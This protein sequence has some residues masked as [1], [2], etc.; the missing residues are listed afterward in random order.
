MSASA[1]GTIAVG[2]FDTY[3][4]M[5]DGE[6]PIDHKDAWAIN[7][8]VAD[9]D[10]VR[11][12]LQIPSSLSGFLSMLTGEED[13]VK[14]MWIKQLLS[15]GYPWHDFMERLANEGR[16]LVITFCPKDSDTA[17]LMTFLPEDFAPFVKK[18]QPSS[19]APQDDADDGQ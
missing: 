10:T 13:N 2:D 8:I 1:Q 14:K 7:S 11:L 6:C 15:F 17:A 3:I 18:K 4:I 16:P 9:G 5:L 12:E 19:P